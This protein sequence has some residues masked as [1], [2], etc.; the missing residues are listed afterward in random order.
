M[1]DNIA[2]RYVQAFRA[3]RLHFQNGLHFFVYGNDVSG[4]RDGVFKNRTNNAVIVNKEHIQ[5]HRRVSHPHTD[6]ARRFEIKQH[7][8]II[9]H[10]RS[11]HQTAFSLSVGYG[12]FDGQFQ[13]R[14]I[15]FAK[16]RFAFFQTSCPFVSVVPTGRRTQKEEEQ[17]K[18]VSRASPFML[19]KSPEL[20]LF[21][22]Y[23]SPKGE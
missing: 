19:K 6:L 14:R 12:C 17:K 16:F 21:F 23:F 4:K 13:R 5:R 1:P 11:E 15:F 10:F 7:S 20:G 3:S 9:V 18:A 8:P 22:F 2:F